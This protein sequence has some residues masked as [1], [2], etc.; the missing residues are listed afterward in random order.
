MQHER[1]QRMHGTTT[2]VSLPPQKLALAMPLA[3]GRSTLPN[4]TEQALRR[5]NKK[6]L[7]MSFH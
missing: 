2:C 4:T 1:N 6:A 3:S 5:Q 7:K